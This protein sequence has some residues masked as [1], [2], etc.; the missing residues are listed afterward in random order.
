MRKSKELWTVKCHHCGKEFTSEAKFLRFR[1][2]VSKG[3]HLYCSR[4]CVYAR[5]DDRHSP[6]PLYRQN[7]NWEGHR[8]F[9]NGYVTI[10]LGKENPLAYKNGYALEHRLVM[11]KLMGRPLLHNEVVHHIDGDK[12]NNTPENLELFSRAATHSVRNI[13]C[14]DCELRVRVRLALRR[15]GELQQEVNELRQ[16]QF[17]ENYIDAKK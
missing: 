9:E 10:Y 17:G 14:R 11:S 16:L 6:A 13:A 2:K 5:K 12:A 3:K 1:L 7:P 8:R 4:R 15:I